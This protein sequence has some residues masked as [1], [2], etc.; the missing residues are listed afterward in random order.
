MLGKIRILV[1]LAMFCPTFVFGADDNAENEVE[2]AEITE[3]QNDEQTQEIADIHSRLTELDWGNSDKP[4][5][6]ELYEKIESLM[7][8][9]G[10]TTDD[11]RQNYEDLKANEQSIENRTLTAVTTAATG[12]GG[13]ELA[14]GLSQQKADKEADANMDAYISTM[15]CT[16]A[17]KSVK[18]GPEEIE[19][20]GGNSTEL[21]NL[22]SEYFAL[23]ADLKARKEAL[24]M[25]PGIESEEILDKSQMGLYDEEFVGITSGSYESL[26]RA[27]VLGSEAD[28][29]KI[30]EQKDA[31]KKRVI[32]GAVAAG[33]GVV[34]GVAGNMII[35]KD[36]PKNR[37][38]EIKNRRDS[39]QQEIDSYLHQELDRCNNI[40]VENQNLANTIKGNSKLMADSNIKDY[41]EKV[42]KLTKLTDIKDISVIKDH[43]LCK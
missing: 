2:N 28:Q 32:G 14:M 21:M 30:D 29:A 6:K 22:R 11:L 24:G 38:E 35:N 31:A 27:K 18:A 1:V 36:A 26:Y 10:Q 5:R 17:D 40:I 20:P 23:A 7:K 3:L 39:I 4:E 34:V 37:V 15:R 25:K 8:D 16:Y 41:V 19:L 9:L 12:I 43:P 13:M 42:S 33:A